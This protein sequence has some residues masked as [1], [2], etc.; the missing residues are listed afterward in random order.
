MPQVALT[1]CFTQKPP[2]RHEFIHIGGEAIIVM[3]C[4]QMHQLMHDDV[5]QAFNGLFRKLQI[6]PDAASSDGAATP[7]GLHLP[8]SPRGNL[9][10]Q[11]LLPFLQQGRH[12]DLQ[13]RSIP[14]LKD[15]LALLSIGA[16]RT[17]KY[18]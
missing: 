16:A 8:D 14:S 11:H 12:H 17:P 18:W 10:I 15:L 1:Q 2:L 9:H 7:L 13:L 5:L 4:Q 6:E 3:P